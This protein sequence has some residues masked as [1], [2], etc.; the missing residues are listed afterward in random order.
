MRRRVIGVLVGGG[1]IVSQVGLYAR[2]AD[3]CFT[4][5]GIFFS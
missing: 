1:A 5:G 3:R 2:K 4:S